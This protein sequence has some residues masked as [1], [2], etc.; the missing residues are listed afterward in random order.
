MCGKRSPADPVWLVS[1]RIQYMLKLLYKIASSWGWWDDA[2]GKALA[3][4]AWQPVFEPQNPQT[5]GRKLEMASGCQTCRGCRGTSTHTYASCIHTIKK[6][7]IVLQ[8]VF[9]LYEIWINFMFRLE[10]HFPTTSLCIFNYQMRRKKSNPKHCW[11]QAFWMRDN[12]PVVI[13]WCMWLFLVLGLWVDCLLRERV[14][15]FCF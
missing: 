1:D 6:F 4:Q 9:K 13:D 8:I 15:R 14:L 10:S 7:K 11:S 2:V 12:Q 5:D 3:E